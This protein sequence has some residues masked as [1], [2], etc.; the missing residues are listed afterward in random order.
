VLVVAGAVVVEVVSAAG[1]SPQAEIN[2]AK[3]R[4]TASERRGAR[5]DTP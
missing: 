1:S 4:R 5:R 2:R 3:A